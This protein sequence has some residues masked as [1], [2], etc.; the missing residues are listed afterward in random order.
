[1]NWDLGALKQA[2][3]KSYGKEHLAKLSPSLNSIFER[4]EFSRFHF[5]ESKDAL[6]KILH[7]K[8]TQAS[9]LNIIF[10]KDSEFD[11]CKFRA[12]AHIISCIQNMHCVSDT[13][14]HVIYYSLNL[15]NAKNES[16]I[17][18]SKVNDWLKSEKKF[19]SLSRMLESLMN[20]EDY[21]YLTALTNHSKHRSI[22][23]PN[24]NVNL[25]N[26]GKDMQEMKF[27]EFEYRK[28]N[29]SSRNTYDFLESE[30]NRESNLI[31]NIG[32]EINHIAYGS[33]EDR[34]LN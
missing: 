25:R 5:H 27:R 33:S 29:Y 1:M 13:L 22:I 12:R 34:L 23:S 26:N 24:F 18:L 14:S 31:I 4:Q 16:E 2:I 30:F 11:E 20:H 8:T 21:K 17:S 3:E 9:L 19:T 28:K 32:N 10:T 6:E 7:D 15:T